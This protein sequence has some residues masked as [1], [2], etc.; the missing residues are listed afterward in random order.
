MSNFAA[1][2]VPPQPPQQTPSQPSR[3]GL[4]VAGFVLGLLGFIG[5][6]VPFVNFFA[7]LLGLFGL[8]LGGIGLA[9]AK[10]AQNGKGLAISGIVLGA[11]AI[12]VGLIVNFVTAKALLDDEDATA[13]PNPSVSKPG[14]NETATPHPTVTIPPVTK[15]TDDPAETPEDNEE[16]D[17]H[18]VIG[19]AQ[20]AKDLDG[21]LALI[22]S[23]TFTNNSDKASRF[24][25]S[26]TDDAFQNGVELSS[27]A[28]SPEDY[29]KYQIDISASIKEIEPGETI[30][31]NEV[32]IL[33]DDS[34]ITIKVH[35]TFSLNRNLLATKIFSVK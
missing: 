19:G 29:D 1:S 23:Y 17:Y 2:Y 28:L 21:K 16:S 3:N 33:L 32:Y 20:M 13:S 10:K 18:V 9:N 24:T 22:V 4:A 25:L 35:E 31:V 12:I 26:V 5:C 11:L 8:I 7:L 6:F 34:P 27:T 15:P 30:E 14:D